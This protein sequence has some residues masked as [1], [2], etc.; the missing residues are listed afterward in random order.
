MLFC[1]YCT[2]II[3]FLLT[4][5]SLFLAFSVYKKIE[6]EELEK[7]VTDAEI[8]EFFFKKSKTNA[9]NSIN[10]K[11]CKCGEEIVND[12]CTEEQILSGCIDYSLYPQI[13]EKNFFRF[14]MSDTQC[15]EYKNKILQIK[16][17]EGQNLNT[18]FKIEYSLIKLL[19][20]GY[21]KSKVLL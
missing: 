17:N 21:F 10:A 11:I 2:S 14:L 13:N 12:F 6:N 3:Y 18:V 20:K 1:V 7:P 9:L 5:A 15:L 19:I 16:T 4:I 8:A